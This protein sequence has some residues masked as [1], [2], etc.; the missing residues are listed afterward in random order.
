M[1]SQ[2][3]K[4]KLK[5]NWGDKSNALDCYAEVKLIDPLSSWCCYIFA[6]DNEEEVI[7]CLLYSDAIG[8]DIYTLNILEIY[9]MYNE[10]GENPVIDDE[11]RRTRVIELLK[12][13]RHD[14]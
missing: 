3:I 12:R 8:V 13:L 6:M 2:I 7:Q 5:K 4:E 1:L 10:H 14:T 9:L 11:F